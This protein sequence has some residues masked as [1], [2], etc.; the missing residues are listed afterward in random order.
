MVL[1]SS[2]GC[3][4]NTVVLRD[5]NGLRNRRSISTREPG[6]TSVISIRPAPA[7]RFPVHS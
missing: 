6:D 2:C 1:P 5:L 7:L 4:E 3:R